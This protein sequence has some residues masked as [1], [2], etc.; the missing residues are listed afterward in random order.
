MGL[1]RVIGQLLT[2]IR[3]PPDQLAVVSEVA[4]NI[5]KQT[6]NIKLLVI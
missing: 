4:N 5:R 2:A 1:A 6:K 3:D